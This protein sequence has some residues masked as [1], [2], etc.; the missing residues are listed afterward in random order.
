MALEV[1]II[2]DPDE[3][4]LGM[5]CKYALVGYRQFQC[6]RCDWYSTAHEAVRAKHI[7]KALS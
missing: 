4:K 7:T 5:K 6:S 3:C 2:E 1:D